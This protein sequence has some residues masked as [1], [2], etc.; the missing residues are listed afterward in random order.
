MNTYTCATCKKQFKRQKSATKRNKS[1]NYFCSRQC[2]A[3]RQQRELPDL[4]CQQCGKTFYTQP[5]R[6]KLS[7]NYCSRTCANQAQSRTLQDMPELR[8]SKGVELQCKNC[9]NSFHVKPYRAKKAKYCSRACAYA[10]KYGKAQKGSGVDVSGQNNPNFKGTNNRVTSRRNATKYF[11][12]KC[13]ICNW[14]IVVDVHHIIPVRD[15]GSNNLNNLA[16]L[17]PNHHAM[18][19]RGMINPDELTELVASAIAQLPDRPPQFD[20]Q[21]SDLHDIFQPKLLS[22]EPE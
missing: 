13:M 18:A 22:V 14:E 11:G 9:E 16:V 19:D 17:C 12:Y 8:K 15:G 6:R 20:L 7:N 10:S 1:G 5:S 3:Q 2:A 21:S 4:E